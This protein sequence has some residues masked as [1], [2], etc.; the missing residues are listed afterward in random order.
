MVLLLSQG[1]KRIYFYTHILEGRTA[2]G[3]RG[4]SF[5]SLSRRTPKND[6]AL[7]ITNFC[8]IA[9]FCLWNWTLNFFP[10]ESLETLPNSY[11]CNCRTWEPFKNSLIRSNT[12]RCIISSLVFCSVQHVDM[13]R[14]AYLRACNT[15][16]CRFTLV[17][18]NTFR[19]F[20]ECRDVSQRLRLR[21]LKT[22]RLKRRSLIKK[23]ELKIV[24]RGNGCKRQS[25]KLVEV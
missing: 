7:S 22:E 25:I 8:K 14:L 11:A 18:C 9:N 20:Q 24:F 6:T 1:N 23:T 16:I 13:Q 2:Q 12:V 5:V 17:K 19:R 4:P 21:F 10:Y 3:W 15:I